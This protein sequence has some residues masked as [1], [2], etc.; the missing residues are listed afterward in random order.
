[1]F[2]KQ[3]RRK[4]KYKSGR[5][6]VCKAE[7]V[8]K[9][10]VNPKIES[11]RL[12][13]KLHY[14]QFG[15][16]IYRSSRPQMFFG[17]GAFKNFTMFTGKRLCWSLF[18]INIQASGLQFYQ[19]KLQHRWLSVKFAKSLKASFL[20]NT[21]VA[22]SGNVL[23]T[24]SLLHMGMMNRVAGWYVMALHRLFHFTVYVSVFSIYFFFSYF[25]CEFY[26][27]LRYWGNFV[28]T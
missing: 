8:R 6:K 20:Q 27:L 3:E 24:L 22:A 23:W 1:M 16:Q 2:S 4:R 11:F 25:F 9:H 21:C 5:N 12:V 15:F 7:E 14:L 19:K 17:T 10:S 26:Y 28:S 13:C 18:L